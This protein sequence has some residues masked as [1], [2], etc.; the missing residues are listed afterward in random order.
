MPGPTPGQ[1]GWYPDGEGHQRWFDGNGWTDHVQPAPTDDSTAAV[2]P[3][4]PGA[5]ELPQAYGAVPPPPPTWH[6][7]GQT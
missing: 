4:A 1:P 6:Q 5:A 3:P 2:P 7:P